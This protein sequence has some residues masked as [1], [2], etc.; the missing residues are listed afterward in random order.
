MSEKEL[1]VTHWGAFQNECKIR[2]EYREAI[3]EATDQIQS[4]FKA[5]LE[6]ASK[7]VHQTKV[8]LDAELGRMATEGMNSPA[9]IGSVWVEW[10]HSHGMYSTCYHK[11]PGPCPNF[12]RTGKVAVLEAVT[13]ASYFAPNRCRP[14][15]GSFILRNLGKDR[16]PGKA[17]IEW[18]GDQR[19]NLWFPDGVAPWEYKDRDRPELVL[20]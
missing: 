4:D 9:P 2:Q 6:S 14:D 5:R 1:R 11:G 7:S 20:E 15:A 19:P 12:K 8:A 10:S 13:P 18:H 16:K 17:F 3:K